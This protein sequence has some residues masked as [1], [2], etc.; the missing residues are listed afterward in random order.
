MYKRQAHDAA[1]RASLQQATTQQAECR[2][3]AAERDAVQKQL[4]ALGS[5]IAELR[6]KQYKDGRQHEL[7][8]RAEKRERVDLAAAKGL[9]KEQGCVA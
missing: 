5:T 1:W 9:R 6:A 8:Q 4:D 7:L 2:Q 3:A